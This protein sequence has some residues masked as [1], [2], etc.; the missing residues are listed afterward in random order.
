V[1]GS[2]GLLLSCY[3]AAPALDGWHPEQEAAFLSAAAALPHVSGL[4]IPLYT[5]GKLHKYDGDWFLQQVRHLPDHLTYVVTTIPDTM[6]QLGRSAAFGLA[7]AVP[8]GREA[9]LARAA[10][11][12]EA[13]RTLNN[14][15]GRKA[16]RAVH[17]Y[18]APRPS[19]REN[20]TFPDTEAAVKALADSLKQLAE[21]DWDDAR[22]VLE[23]CDA[24]TNHHPPVKGFLPFDHEIAAVLTAGTGAG[25]AVNWARSVIEGRDTGTPDRHVKMALQAGLLAGVVLSGCSSRPT[26][27]GGAWDDAHLPPAPLEPA[28]L[29][30][31]Q[32]VRSIA[33]T[34]DGASTGKVPSAY[35][36][37]KVSAPQGAGVVQRLSILARSINEVREAGF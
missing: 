30:T 32:G 5:T 8:A 4:E 22:P 28:S 9:A 23:H 26:A 20:G 13:V 27:F 12:S 35:R 21:Y 33:A 34:L 24:A 15:L 18:S 37:L 14:A 36:G 1:N 17:L 16:V 11:A 2:A 19:T 3:A 10:A 6:D 31:A 29:L 7:S 25:I